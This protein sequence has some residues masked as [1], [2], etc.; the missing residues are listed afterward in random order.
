MQKIVGTSNVS[1]LA[2]FYVS[3]LTASVPLMKYL[4]TMFLRRNSHA[5][6]QESASTLNSFLSIFY[7]IERL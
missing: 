2:I 1:C 7:T 4:G 3:K 6:S 5:A